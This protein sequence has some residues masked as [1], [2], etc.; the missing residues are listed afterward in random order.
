MVV[1]YCVE[2]ARENCAIRLIIGPSPRKIQL[3]AGYRLTLGQGIA[4]TQGRDAIMFAY[5]PVM[6]HEAL[7]A[8]ELLSEKGLILKIVN[9]PW[10]NRV[11]SDWLKETVHP[12]KNVYVL[13][14]HAPVG[15]LGDCLLNELMKANL[16]DG[17]RLKKFAVEGYPACGTPQ[18][19]LRFHGLDGASLA[20]HILG[21]SDTPVPM[22]GSA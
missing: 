9:M 16:L 19:V 1:E 17:R 18:E 3:P 21:E 12:Y 4:L 13:E 22:K 11:N 2:Q 10:L 8:S 20:N 7:L 6:L 15:G 14:D 5:G